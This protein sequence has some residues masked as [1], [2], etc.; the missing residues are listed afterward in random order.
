[1]LIRVDSIA[2]LRTY[3]GRAWSVPRKDVL[4]Q[5]PFRRSSQRS[6]D[7][8]VTSF[9]EAYRLATLVRCWAKNSMPC[10]GLV[11]PGSGRPLAAGRPGR[12]RR[13][14]RWRRLM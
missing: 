7:R 10:A 12:A 8:D 6:F 2:E 3:A 11:R 1:M 14:P 4:I 5:L 13:R 9:I